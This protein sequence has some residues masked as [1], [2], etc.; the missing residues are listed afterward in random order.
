[1][2]LAIGTQP[3][4]KRISFATGVIESRRLLMKGKFRERLVRNR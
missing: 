1:M 3:I 4:E 2:P